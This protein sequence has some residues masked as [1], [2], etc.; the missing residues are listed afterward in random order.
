[1]V[2]EPDIPPIFRN[3]FEERALQIAEYLE[4]EGRFG[5]LRSFNYSD[6][7]KLV[8]TCFEA[9]GGR[10]MVF[11]LTLTKRDASYVSRELPKAIT[12]YDRSA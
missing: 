5:Y 6:P 2:D 8:V 9:A 3:A 12:A 11:E 10:A 1:M 7:N 4:L